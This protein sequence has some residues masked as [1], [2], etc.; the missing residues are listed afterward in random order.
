MYSHFALFPSGESL[1]NT[2][3][4]Q[5]HPLMVVC[6]GFSVFNVKTL[7]DQHIFEVFFEALDHTAHNLRGVS[8]SPTGVTQ[9]SRAEVFNSLLITDAAPCRITVRLVRM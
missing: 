7:S 4:F 2:S 5:F 6:G 3:S 8:V 1:K 9:V